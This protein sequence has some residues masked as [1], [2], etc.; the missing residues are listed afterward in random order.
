MSGT[1]EKNNFGRNA[2]NF[3]AKDIVAI[4]KASKDLGIKKLKVSDLVVEFQD[5]TK[6]ELE[7][8]NSTKIV[9]FD[10]LGNYTNET[11]NELS[12]EEKAHLLFATDPLK[13]EEM[14]DSKEA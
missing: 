14:L 2:L 8:D 7:L 9:P 4:L 11:T 6:K 12:D 3:E 10:T 1:M 5:L 13:Y